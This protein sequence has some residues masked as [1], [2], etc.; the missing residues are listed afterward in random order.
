LPCSR[1]SK[2]VS[3]CRRAM[4]ARRS[5]DLGGGHAILYRLN[6]IA[7]AKQHFKQ[8]LLASAAQYRDVIVVSSGDGPKS[9]KKDTVG[10][11]GEQG[12][13]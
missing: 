8:R 7:I 4:M 12:I 5:L 2:P 11:P 6:N 9:R 13:Q 3:N 10:A 1:E